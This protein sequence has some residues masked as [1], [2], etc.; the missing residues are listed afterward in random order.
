MTLSI[1]HI[2]SNKCKTGR[3]NGIASEL[4]SYGLP[5]K[6]QTGFTLAELIAV[7]VIIGI[8]ATTAMARFFERN[9]FDSRSFYDQ[10]IST[11]RYAQK[12]AIAQHRFVCVEFSGNNIT[13]TYDQ[14]PPSAVHSTANCPGSMLSSPTGQ[15][16]FTLT[17]PSGIILTGGSAFNFNALGRP[18][19]AQKNI[20]VGGYATAITVEAETGYVH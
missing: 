16:P 9:A 5:Q 12:A 10:A 13:L 14:T 7:L 20:I 8:L 4:I 3:L 11:L 19:A 2:Q 17:A 15:A 18:S 1:G 6:I